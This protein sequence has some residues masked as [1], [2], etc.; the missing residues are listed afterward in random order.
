MVVVATVVVVDGAVVVVGVVVVVVVGA[1]VVVVRAVVVVD[2]PVVAV[3]ISSMESDVLV[4]VSSES[5]NAAARRKIQA[6]TTAVGKATRPS[7]GH[8]L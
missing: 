3:V 7:T 8:D 2:R 6:N 5:P 1:V 4:S